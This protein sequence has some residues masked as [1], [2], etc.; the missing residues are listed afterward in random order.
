MHNYSSDRGGNG[1]GQFQPKSSSGVDRS[2]SNARI[3]VCVGSVRETI[4]GLEGSD[5]KVINGMHTCTCT[6]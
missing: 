2:R 6:C 1:F 4:M 5:V 3:Q